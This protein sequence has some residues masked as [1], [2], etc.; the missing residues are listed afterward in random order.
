[1]P[2]ASTDEQLALHASIREW[3][4]RAAVID[5]VRGLEPGAGRADLG[6]ALAQLTES[7]VPGPVLPALIAGLVLRGR[8]GSESA[9]SALRSLTAGDMSVAAA[10]DAGSVTAQ[11]QPDGTATLTGTVGPVLGGGS[12]TQLLLPREGAR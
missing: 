1:L 12:T 3:A 11:R 10:L 4:K 7:L 9:H 5:V 8:P 2:I 6:A